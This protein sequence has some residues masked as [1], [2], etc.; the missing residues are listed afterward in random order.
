VFKSIDA[1]KTWEKQPGGVS[2]NT[3]NRAW[4]VGDTVIV[5]PGYQGIYVKTGLQGA[6]VNEYLT[7]WVDYTDVYFMND[8]RG[9]ITTDDGDVYRASSGPNDWS[10]HALSD[11]LAFT[12]IAFIDSFG[13]FLTDT[14]TIYFSSDSGSTWKR[15]DSA[16]TERIDCIA[17]VD[18][19]GYKFIYGVSSSGKPIRIASGDTAVTVIDSTAKSYLQ[20]VFPHGDTLWGIYYDSI[21]YSIDLGKT[22]R[23]L[24]RGKTKL[25]DLDFAGNVGCAVGIYGEILTIAKDKM[26]VTDID[27]SITDNFTDAFLL[28]P[29]TGLITC[30]NGKIYRSIDGGKTLAKVF[31]DAKYSLKA[32]AFSDAKKGYAVGMVSNRGVILGTSDAGESWSVLRDSLPGLL[33]DIMFT[34]KKGWIAGNRGLLMVS[35]DGGAK[36]TRVDSGSVGVDFC[37]LGSFPSGDILIGAKDSALYK[38]SAGKIVRKRTGTKQEWAVYDVQ[39]I[40]D[41]LAFATGTRYNIMTNSGSILRTRDAGETWTEVEVSHCV[42]PNALF[43]INGKT[44]WI[45]EE[46]IASTDSANGWTRQVQCGNKINSFSNA[47]N[48]R[49]WAVGARGQLYVLHDDRI[50]PCKRGQEVRQAAAGMDIRMKKNGMLTISLALSNPEKIT[51]RLFDGRGRAVAQ[52]LGK[53]LSAGSHDLSFP[54]TQL[55]SG[56]YL[57]FVQSGVRKTVKRIVA[58]D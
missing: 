48:G 56:S 49:V 31:S 25:L 45:A 22:W 4:F 50:S 1:G 16:C 41:T 21:K 46:E 19:A 13:C 43:F 29:K 12:Q 42:F 3:L 30:D 47:A 55:P 53:H 20:R 51:I 7:Y 9:F 23:T 35:D 58:V 38:C 40:N 26:T 10:W 5:A 6:W 57:C 8:R 32:I 37:S 39:C 24:G 18:S 27:S 15:R 28:D 2:A 36:W 11:N 33:T 34:S 17:P 44:G 54:M 52:V 14:K